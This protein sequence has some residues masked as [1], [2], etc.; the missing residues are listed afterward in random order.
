[1]NL[2]ENDNY[3]K[4]LTAGILQQYLEQRGY[5]R[6]L[7]ASDTN[8]PLQ[9]ERLNH[10]FKSHFYPSAIILPHT[11]S[12]QRCCRPFWQAKMFCSLAVQASAKVVVC[13][14]CWMSWI[15]S[16]FRTWRF[17]LTKRFPKAHRNTTAKLGI[18]GFAS[19][20]PRKPGW[21]VVRW[22][23]SS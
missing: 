16:I 21:P 18:Q 7:L 19:A 9:I 11:G 15:M 10:R 14:H 17:Q 3:G 4:T 20:L 6:R 1:M 13:K 22:A 5:Q 8:I 23:F 12:S 2:T